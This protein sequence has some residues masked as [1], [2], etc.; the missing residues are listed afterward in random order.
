LN[1]K[2]KRRLHWE[3]DTYSNS[4]AVKSYVRLSRFN[5]ILSIFH[6][7]NNDL[8]K[9]E[10]C[11]FKINSLIDSICLKFRKYYCP[12]QSFALDESLITYRGR[13]CFKYY[14]HFSVFLIYKKNDKIFQQNPINGDTNF[15][16]FV[17]LILGIS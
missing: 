8:N 16:V 14:I 5:M 1:K 4:P 9:T 2:P 12:G 6:L 13:V 7:A 15:I 11:F 10:H 17:I 3:G